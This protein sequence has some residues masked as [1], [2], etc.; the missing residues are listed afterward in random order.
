[1]RKGVIGRQQD[2]AKKFN[3]EEINC[4][5]K[6][7]GHIHI[8][9]AQYTQLTAEK[10]IHVDRQLLHCFTQTNAMLEIGSGPKD[11]QGKLIGGLTHAC[12]GVVGT[13]FGAEAFIPTEIRLCCNYQ[14]M[15]ALEEQLNAKLKTNQKLLN[16]MILLLPRYKA[17][18]KTADNMKKNPALDSSRKTYQTAGLDLEA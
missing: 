14:E 13:H 16:D 8:G 11:R 5:L 17:L 15:M 4:H 18:S 1:V 2:N 7:A 3:L 12:K 9:F 6:A 10:D